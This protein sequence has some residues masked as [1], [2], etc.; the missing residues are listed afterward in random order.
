MAS[1]HFGHLLHRFELRAHGAC[2]PLIQEAP[3]PVVDTAT[4]SP[5]EVRLDF[6]AHDTTPRHETTRL[7][8]SNHER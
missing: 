1:E 7:L 3:G 8:P 6:L 4:W 2:T 5:R